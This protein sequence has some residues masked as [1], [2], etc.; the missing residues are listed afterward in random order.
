[1]R[2]ASAICVGVASSRFGAV[3]PDDEAALRGDLVAA[4]AV[5]GEEPEPLADAA[6]LRIRLRNRRAAE[7]ADVLHQ[8]PELVVGERRAL[9]H[10][11]LVRLIDRHVARRQV[12]VRGL[13]ADSLQRRA[14][15][16]PSGRDAAAA[17]AVAADTVLEVE[18]RAALRASQ[19]RQEEREQSDEED[20]PPHPCLQESRVR[21]C[22]P[23][24]AIRTT[25]KS[26]A[27]IPVNARK[28][29]APRVV[30]APVGPAPGQ[31]GRSRR[32]ESDHPEQNR[33]ARVIHGFVSEIP[34]EHADSSI[35]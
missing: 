16:L 4:G 27:S 33:D 1:M 30:S 3:P 11:L 7:R 10:G 6:A 25:K 17:A 20:A 19:L 32:A 15:V 23:P 12:E 24:S 22:S 21:S 18:V 31:E 5:L 29:T 14:E 13:R 34:C 35:P 8:R 2:T 28:D 26:P 9:A